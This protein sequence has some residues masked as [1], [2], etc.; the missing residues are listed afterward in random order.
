[1]TAADQLKAIVERIERLEGE[2]AV[3]AGEIGDIFK[4]AKGNGFDVKA[5]KIVLRLRK[6]TKAER[7]A[8]EEIVDT[9]AQHL[10]L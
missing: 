6:L 3:L 8:Q 7:A 10:G 9:Y 4:E 5:L 1:M 2:K